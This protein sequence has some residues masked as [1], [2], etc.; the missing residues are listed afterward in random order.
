MTTREQSDG[1]ERPLLDV[2]EGVDGQSSQPLRPAGSTTDYS[3]SSIVC[4]YLTLVVQ[5]LIMTMTSSFFPDSDVGITI[6]NTWQ[7]FIFAAFPFGSMV[8]SPFVGPIMD[9]IQ[10]RTTL[11]I[12]LTSM[13]VFILS[14]GAVPFV[15]SSPAAAAPT[16][17]V[18]AFLYGCGSTLAELGAYTILT[19][20]GSAR[21]NLGLLMS[22]GEVMVGT[23]AML[24]PPVGGGLYAWGTTMDLDQNLRFMFPFF[25]AAALPLLTLASV[26]VFVPPPKPLAGSDADETEKNGSSNLENDAPDS[27]K[28]RSPC[29]M[30]FRQALFAAGLIAS[31]LSYASCRPTL[32]IRL[33]YLG[34]PESSLSSTTGLVFLVG[35]G[36]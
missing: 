2:A 12:G 31:A 30:T 13:A 24:G 17:L 27:T 22:L 20:T 34:V 26:L 8:T 9:R 5:W 18:I 7:G 3:I 29:R 28:S 14:F 11:I 21:G 32:E 10:K 35:G 1:L 19:Q 16:F 36:T 33:K 6:S 4:L 25:W 23:G 15:L